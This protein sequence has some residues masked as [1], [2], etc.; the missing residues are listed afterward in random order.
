MERIPVP[1][2]FLIEL[3]PE[4]IRQLNKNR[5]I[6]MRLTLKA[7]SIIEVESPGP[8]DSNHSQV[9]KSEPKR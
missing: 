3:S 5:E 2:G 6:A 1:G 9:A 8:A 4:E 7:A